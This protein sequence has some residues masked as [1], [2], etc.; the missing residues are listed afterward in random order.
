MATAEIRRHVS[1]AG[2]ASIAR[3]TRA[4]GGHGEFQHYSGTEPIKEADQGYF[5]PHCIKNTLGL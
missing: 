1:T 2:S 4:S 3:Y 5:V